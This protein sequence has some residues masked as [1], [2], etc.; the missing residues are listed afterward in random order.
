LKFLLDTNVVSELSRAQPH[1]QVIEWLNSVSEGDICLSATSIIE[2]RFGVEILPAGRRKRDLSE[3]LAVTLSE[4]F[5]DR[6]LPISERIADQAGR[7]LAMARGRGQTMEVADVLIGATAAAHS[8]TLVTRNTRHFAMLGLPLFD[9]WQ[10][11]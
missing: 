3:W 9:P 11:V 8:L 2:M 1:L 10:P 4:R 6:I 5:S 7:F